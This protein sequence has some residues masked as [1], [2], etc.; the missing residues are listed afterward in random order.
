MLSNPDSAKRYE[1]ELLL[2]QADWHS[3]P[4]SLTFHEHS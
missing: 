2:R 4:I 1:I 3:V